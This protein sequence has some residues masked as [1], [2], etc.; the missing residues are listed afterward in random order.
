M[1]PKLCQLFVAKKVKSRSTHRTHSFEQCED[2]TMLSAVPLFHSNSMSTNKIFL[3]FDGQ[4][5]SDSFWTNPTQKS[6]GNGGNTIHAPVYNIA[7]D[8]DYDMQGNAL[9]FSPDELKYIE[10][11]WKLVA[12][13]YAP[14]NVDVTTEEPPLDYFH[15]QCH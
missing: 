15:Q 14:F 13:D 1:L 4:V 8:A 7:G 12:E 11:A 6:V 9:P 2:R 5:V 3:D 10:M